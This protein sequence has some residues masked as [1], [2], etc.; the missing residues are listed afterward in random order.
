MPTRQDTLWEQL[1]KPVISNLIDRE[2]LER[3]AQSVDWDAETQRITNPQTTYPRYYQNSFHG[4][5]GGYLTVTAAVTYDPITQYVL[6]PQET[7]VR[8]G[9]IDRVKVQPRRIL[10]LGC[11]TGTTTLLL[12]QTFPQA[13]VIG[14]DLSP[15]LLV[16]AAHKARQANLD[17]QW[18]HGNAEATG[19]PA[20]SFDLISIALLFHE[21]PA[22]VTQGILR[23]SFRLLAAG[24]QIIILDGNQKTLAQMP[25]LRNVFEEPFIEDYAAGNLD[26]GLSAAG[27]GAVQTEDWWL[28]HQ[29]SQGVKPLPGATP[30]PAAAIQTDPG[31]DS[32]GEIPA[33]A[34]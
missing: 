29:L 12:K 25:W 26:A 13:Q 28:V 34:F 19:L 18:R 17:M 22:A 2:K 3:F 31:L 14:L 7:W 9:A 21:T 27:F 1:L 6:P 16:V 20:A 10:D 8:Q 5:E 33:P 15:Y 24:G 4:I 30:Q 23:E 11:G 32:L